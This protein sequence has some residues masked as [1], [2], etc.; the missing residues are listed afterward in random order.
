MYEKLIDAI[1]NMREKEAIDLA[2]ELLRSKAFD[3]FVMLERCTEA[4][5]AVGKRFESGEY[6]LP[7][8]MMAGDMLRVI[9]ELVKP[10]MQ[11]SGPHREKKGRVLIGTVKGD[12]HDIGKNIV[13]FLLDVNGYEVRD[14]GIDM[15]PEQFV[16]GI[17]AFQPQVVGMSGLLTLAY[18]SMR[19]TV[20]AIEGAKL[21]DSVKI[22]IGGAQM[23]ERV[24]EYSGADAYAKDAMDGVALTKKWIGGE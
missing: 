4:M 3:P 2:K 22:M 5:E 18:D 20:K 7:E 11:G 19:D 1:V 15:S 17:K 24:K 6:F 14:I 23:S 9:S 21:R 12:I 13:T 10:M 8:L 16:E